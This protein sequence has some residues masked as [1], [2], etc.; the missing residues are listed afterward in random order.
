[1][2]VTE[3]RRPSRTEYDQL[4]PRGGNIQGALTL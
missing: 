4:L 3:W 1:M 2:K